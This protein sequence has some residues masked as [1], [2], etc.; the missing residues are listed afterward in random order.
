M[1]FILR[2]KVEENRT[3]ITE[4]LAKLNGS[5][6]EMIMISEKPVAA[7]KVAA[8]VEE[9][10]TIQVYIYCGLVAALFVVSLI[11][12]SAFLNICLNS[13]IELHRR[14]FHGVMRASMRFF[15]VNPAGRVLNRFAKDI[16]NTKYFIKK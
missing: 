4:Q 1:I 7:D 16:G 12:N 10:R 15:E 13:S 9:S 6:S 2:T 8:M 3:P 14:L 5:S 11:R